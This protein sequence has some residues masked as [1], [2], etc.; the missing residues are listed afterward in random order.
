M[1]LPDVLLADE[2]QVTRSEHA[3]ATA[4]RASSCVSVR[5]P[6]ALRP[7]PSSPLPLPAGPRQLELGGLLRLGCC[8][9][10]PSTRPP[11]RVGGYEHGLLPLCPG[12][13]LSHEPGEPGGDRVGQLGGLPVVGRLLAAGARSARGPGARTARARARSVSGRYGWWRA[14]WGRSS[15]GGWGACSSAWPVLPAGGGPGPGRVGPL[16]AGYLTARPRLAAAFSRPW[17]ARL[18]AGSVCGYGL[19][20]SPGL[21]PPLT[22]PLPGRAGATS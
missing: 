4:P 22:C 13:L 17:I 8:G 6:A 19:S 15:C 7:H 10:S 20:P 14:S 5:Q 9:L 3:G 1:L 18:A 21:W 11:G 16:W 12:L 2:D